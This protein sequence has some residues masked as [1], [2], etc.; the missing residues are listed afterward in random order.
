MLSAPCVQ[1]V[2]VIPS[3]GD[4]FLD[5][6]LR[7][8]IEEGFGGEK[9]SVSVRHDVEVTHRRDVSVFIRDDDGSMLS[10]NSGGG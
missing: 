8:V 9:S 5:R 10:R 1:F 6:G 4:V 7:L 3:D 2:S